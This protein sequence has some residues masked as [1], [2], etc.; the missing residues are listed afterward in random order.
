MDLGNRIAAW[1]KAVGMS[2][3][4][5]AIKLGLS[6][7]AVNAWVKNHAAPTHSN[8]IAIVEALGV[9]MERFYGRVPKKAK[10]AA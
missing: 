7:G 6:P 9:S 1:L 4:Q 8:M 2:Q 5:L 3:R 10:A